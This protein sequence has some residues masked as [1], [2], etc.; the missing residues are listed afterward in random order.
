MEISTSE[1]NGAV[2]ITIKTKEFTFK[3]HGAFRKSY[4]DAKADRAIV[5]F[6]HVDYVDS[7]ALGMLLIIQKEFKGGV[8]IHNCN[9]KLTRV[10]KVANFDKIFNFK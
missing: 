3:S 4:E 9:E 5:D 1:N 7:S 8:E 6:R 10:F 2:T